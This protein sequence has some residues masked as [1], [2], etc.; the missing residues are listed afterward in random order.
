YNRHYLMDIAPQKIS[1][2]FRHK[3]PLSMVLMDVDKFKSINDTYG[4]D[5]GDIVLTSIGKLLVECCRTED[6]VARFGGEEFVIILM[7]CDKENAIKKMDL[8]RQQLS[9]L[10]PADLPVTASFGVTTLEFEKQN[11]FAEL[12]SAADKAVYRAKDEGRNRVVFSN[13]VQKIA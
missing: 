12:F 9:E 8:L 5:T 4:H 2:A 13:L 10:K 7:H 3:I 11:G 1:E 6:I